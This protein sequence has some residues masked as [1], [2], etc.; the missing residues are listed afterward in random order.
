MSTRST[1]ASAKTVLW[2][3]PCKRRPRMSASRAAFLSPRY[4]HISYSCVGILV[5][6]MRNVV[7]LYLTPAL[8]DYVNVAMTF[9]I[10]LFQQLFGFEPSHYASLLR[11]SLSLCHLD[12]SDAHYHQAHSHIVP[13]PK[14]TNLLPCSFLAIGCECACCQRH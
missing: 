1:T 9:T 7:P 13:T 8:C 14:H 12:T 4:V 3:R 10:L 6:L 2:Q 5:C 11:L